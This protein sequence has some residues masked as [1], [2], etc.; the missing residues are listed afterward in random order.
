MK[1]LKKKNGG[2][3]TLELMVA[4]VILILNITAV[5]LIINGGQSVSIDS[6]TN[7]EAIAKAKTILE[8]TGATSQKDFLSVVSTTSTDTSDA[9][10]YTKNLIVS[11]LTSCK[12]EIISNI[13]WLTPPMRTQKIELTTLLTDIVGAL[14]LGGDCTV[15]PPRT[16]WDSPQGFALDTF[17]PGKP[18]TM[19]VFN[20]I[21]YLGSDQTPFL[22]IADTNGAAL[23]QNSGLFVAYTN[24]FNLGAIPNSIDVIKWIDP[25][26]GVEKRY[27]LLAMDTP[28]NQLKVVDVTNINAPVL[29]ATLTLSPCVAGSFPEGWRLY[30]YKDRLY[31][32]TR[33][34]AGPE[35]H[36]FDISN[37]AS[38]TELGSGACKG[39]DLGSTA[40]SIEVRDQKITGNTTRFVYLSTDQDSKELRVLNATNPLSIYDVSIANQNLPGSQ[41]GQSV[42]IIG[43]KLYFGR[44]STPQGVD[45]YVFDISNPLSGLPLLGSQDIG[46]GVIGIRVAGSL[47][48]LATPK[49]NKEFQIWNIANLASISLVKEYSFRNIIDQGVDYETD[50]IYATS[51]STPNFQ[52]LYDSTP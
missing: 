8:D 27:A 2:T 5:V 33:F 50:F 36:V 34:T 38:P 26:S 43:N 11:D 28:T 35:F 1:D 22:E 14:A 40:E 15:D 46:T 51:Q 31:F 6:E 29:V 48:F 32:L 47:G 49:V 52:I 12:K 42:F 21:A 44:Q 19:D 18:T 23:G 17:N 25:Y 13:S 10:I 39:F 9:L 45:L 37:P 30:A 16:N 24:G 41:D 7:E 20:K 3:A 4:F